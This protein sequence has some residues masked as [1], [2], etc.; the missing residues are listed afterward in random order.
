MFQGGL[1]SI[2]PNEKRAEQH[3]VR[4]H[5]NHRREQKTDSR[6]LCGGALRVL[7]G[8]RHFFLLFHTDYNFAACVSFI[9]VSES[10]GGV[11]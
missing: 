1:H 11:T 9:E 10:L 2:A 3:V 8:N 7:D 5:H 4:E 6:D